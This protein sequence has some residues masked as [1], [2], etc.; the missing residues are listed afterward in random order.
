MVGDEGHRFILG[1][2]W[3]Y[4]LLLPDTDF[5]EPSARAQAEGSVEPSSGFQN[6]SERW[7]VIQRE[8]K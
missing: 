2:T 3:L 1:E 7:I 4:N 6:A 5:G 8:Q